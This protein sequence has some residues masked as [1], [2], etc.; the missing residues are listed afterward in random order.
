M[1]GINGEKRE[2]EVAAAV[3]E[4]HDHALDMLHSNQC[5]IVYAKRS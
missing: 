5:R 1:E 4:E 2:K 3:T